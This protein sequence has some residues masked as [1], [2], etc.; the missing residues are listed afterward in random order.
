MVPVRPITA[1]LDVK[2]HKNRH[3][4][5]AWNCICNEVR[6]RKEAVSYLRSSGKIYYCDGLRKP[7]DRGIKRTENNTLMMERIEP[8]EMPTLYHTT[9]IHIRYSVLRQVQ[10]LF[11]NDLFTES[12][13]LLPLSISIIVSFP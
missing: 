6:L 9:H 11:Q 12:G 8:S 7:V 1:V 13:L 10:S 2:E 4:Q 5:G 3:I